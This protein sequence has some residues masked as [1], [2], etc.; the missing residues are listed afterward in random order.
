MRRQSAPIARFHVSGQISH[1][2]CRVLSRKCLVTPEEELG[3]QD[4]SKALHKASEKPQDRLG[5]LPIAEPA[6]LGDGQLAMITPVSS[7]FVETFT[8]A[9]RR[10][11][12]AAIL[13]LAATLIFLHFRTGLFPL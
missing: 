13:F 5:W 12:A 2:A 8:L 10:R 9:Q 6:R 7:Y 11:C 1:K 4:R 3:R